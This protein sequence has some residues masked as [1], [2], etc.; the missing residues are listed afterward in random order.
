M[1]EQD[2]EIIDVLQDSLNTAEKSVAY[3]VAKLNEAVETKERYVRI[4]SKMRDSSAPTNDEIDALWYHQLEQYYPETLSSEDWKELVEAERKRCMESPSY[5][6]AHYAVI[7]TAD[8]EVRPS[9][10]L[11]QRAARLLLKK[12]GQR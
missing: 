4:I 12:K 2:K 3:Y 9:N 8:G 10:Y 11:V 1:T 5:F 7:A 6:F